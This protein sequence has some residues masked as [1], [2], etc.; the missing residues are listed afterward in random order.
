MF[1]LGPALLGPSLVSAEDEEEE[2]KMVDRKTSITGELE[3]L[4][5]IREVLVSQSAK[6]PKHVTDSFDLSSS[7]FVMDTNVLVGNPLVLESFLDISATVLIPA[8]VLEELVILCDVPEKAP[9]AKRALHWLESEY[10]HS[11]DCKL[12]VSVAHASGKIDRDFRTKAEILSLGTRTNDDLILK[13]GQNLAKH[14][15]PGGVT[16]TPVLVS[17]DVNFRLKAK[18]LGLRAISQDAF[19]RA[20]L[21]TSA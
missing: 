7:L 14:Q 17:D 13:M 20:S 15:F 12:S 9:K 19:L 6:S 3:R 10:E 18:A 1:T 4:K 21:Y 5:G 16:M 8:I 2:E 11:G